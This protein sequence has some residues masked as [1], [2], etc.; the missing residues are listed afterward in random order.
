MACGA[1]GSEKQREFSAEMIIHFPGREGLEKPAV[2]VL[3]K[4]MVCFTCGCTVF[5]IPDADIRL[6]EEGA[7]ADPEVEA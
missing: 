5:T 1:C 6:L 3:T 7:I 2:P 4:L